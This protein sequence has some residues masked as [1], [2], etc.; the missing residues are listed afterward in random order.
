MS[1]DFNRKK[2]TLFIANREN[3]ELT[4]I[5]DVDSFN[6]EEIRALTDYGEVMI[7]GSA[8]QVETLETENGVLKISGNVD[9]VVYTNNKPAKSFFKRVFS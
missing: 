5:T 6:E 7:K 4:G 1:D 2:H 9:A 3:A 8:L